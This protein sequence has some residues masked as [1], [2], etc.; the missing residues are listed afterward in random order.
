[1]TTTATEINVNLLL[2]GV[3]KALEAQ[4]YDEFQYIFN[5]MVDDDL[6]GVEFQ[7]LRDEAFDA[8]RERLTISYK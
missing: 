1:M 5:Q 6:D 8:V 4:V 2:D 3:V 7:N